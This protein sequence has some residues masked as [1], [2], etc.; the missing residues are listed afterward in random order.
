MLKK[1]CAVFLVLCCPALSSAGMLVVVAESSPL[2]EMD[3]HEVRQLYKWACEHVNMPAD[4]KRRA[5]A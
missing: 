5:S 3:R 1:V 2:A 4:R